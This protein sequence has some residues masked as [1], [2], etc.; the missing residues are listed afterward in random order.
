MLQHYA[1]SI[2]LKLIAAGCAV[3]M[4]SATVLLA[5]V[6]ATRRDVWA[7]LADVRTLSAFLILCTVPNSKTHNF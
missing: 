6:N 7:T 3:V 1:S 5:W 2:M 4:A